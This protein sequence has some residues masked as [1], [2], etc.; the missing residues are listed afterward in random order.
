MSLLKS[1]QYQELQCPLY[2]PLVQD[3]QEAL[4]ALA[5]QVAL[6]QHHKMKLSQRF[7]VFL[8]SLA[9]LAGLFHL[10]TP[11]VQENLF[12]QEAQKVQEVQEV[13]VVHCRM[14]RMIL[15]WLQSFLDLPSLL[16]VLVFHILADLEDQ[17]ALEVLVL[18]LLGAQEDQVG[19]VVLEFQQRHTASQPWMS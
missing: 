2:V 9:H 15:S 16:L 18:N 5:V 1:Q 10:G 13:L 3:V 8:G 17:G 4:A 14:Y 6:V 19:Q 7:L 11:L 12:V